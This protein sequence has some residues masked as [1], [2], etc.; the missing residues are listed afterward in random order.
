MVLN[1]FAAFILGLFST[2]HCLGM[3]GGIITALSLGLP[4]A[5]RQDRGRS[6]LLIAGYNLG[7]ILS[8]SLAG[9]LAGGAGLVF[10][11]ALGGGFGY[12]IL[13]GLAALILVLLGLHLAGWMTALKYLE[14]FGLRI[15]QV[16][17]PIGGYFLPVDNFPKA[18]LLGCIWGWLPCG[19]VYSVLLWSATS[20]DPVAATG[21][22]FCFGLGTLPA[23][24]T[25]GVF[26]DR[27]RKMASQG[28][29]RKAFGIIIILL[30][31][32]SPWFNPHMHNPSASP[33]GHHQHE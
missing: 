5:V 1:L 27:L 28:N 17:R 12:A 8:Y 32:S 20:A 4:E 7:R 29:L 31:L 3:C 9:A 15:W 23:L 25:A 33:A 16:L 13:R 14:G 6:I 22:M 18:L 19:L 21:Y 26:S 30:G 2:V 10:N 24:I 11:H